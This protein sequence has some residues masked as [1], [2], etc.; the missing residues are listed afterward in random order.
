[1]SVAQVDAALAAATGDAAQR[2][3]QAQAQLRCGTNCGSCLPKLRGLAQQACERG[4]RDAQSLAA[5]S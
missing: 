1:V 2:V 5:H 3:A 4:A